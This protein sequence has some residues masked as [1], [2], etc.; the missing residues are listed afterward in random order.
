MCLAIPMR[1]ESIS[2]DIGIVDISGVKRNIGLTLI[3]NPRV[4]DYL[5]VHAGFAIQK[6]DEKEAQETIR[7]LKELVE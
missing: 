6:I 4:G 3:E 7:L 1:L 5:L 2:G